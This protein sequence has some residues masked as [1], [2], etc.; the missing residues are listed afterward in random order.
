V[1]YSKRIKGKIKFNTCLHAEII[2]PDNPKYPDYG[3]AKKTPI[4]YCRLQVK[5]VV[6]SEDCADCRFYEPLKVRV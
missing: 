5:T 4:K 2:T 6:P 1:N 3:N